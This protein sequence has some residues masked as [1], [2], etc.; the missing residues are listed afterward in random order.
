MW[1]R[2]SIGLYYL[3][4]ILRL[5]ICYF[6]ARDVTCQDKVQVKSSHVVPTV[7]VIKLKMN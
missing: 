6:S 1:V 5:S 2:L 7:N 4:V 3:R